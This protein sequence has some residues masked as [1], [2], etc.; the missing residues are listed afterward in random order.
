MQ[1]LKVQGLFGITENA[2]FQVQRV[3]RQE[4]GA[5]VETGQGDVVELDIQ[6]VD[7]DFRDAVPGNK[8]AVIKTARQRRRQRIQRQHG[9]QIGEALGQLAIVE[10]QLSL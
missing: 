5:G 3:Q 9:L 8:N 1:I 4:L 2:A 10:R 6:V 7:C